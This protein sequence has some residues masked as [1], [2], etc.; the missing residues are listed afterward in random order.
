MPS[1]KDYAKIAS[2]LISAEPLSF[3]AYPDGSLVVI[4]PTGQKFTFTKEQVQA[5]SHSIVSEP[6]SKPSPKPKNTNPEPSK[7]QPKR[8]RPPKAKPESK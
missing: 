3:K 1:Q 4:A 8:G 6:V 2:K 7:P 5:I